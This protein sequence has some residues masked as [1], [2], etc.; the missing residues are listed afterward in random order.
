MFLPY[1]KAYISERMTPCRFVTVFTIGE[2]VTRRPLHLAFAGGDL[3][4]LGNKI[5][6]AR[7]ARFPG[8]FLVASSG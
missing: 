8:M 3:E 5:A 1:R 2:L 4:K 7:P 6:L